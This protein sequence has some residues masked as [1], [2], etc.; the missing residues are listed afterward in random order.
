MR[1]ALLLTSRLGGGSAGHS[2]HL[3]RLSRHCAV[4]RLAPLSEGETARLVQ[5]LLDR[6]AA[7]LEL[8]RWIQAETEGNPLFVVET[9]RLLQRQ[10]HIEGFTS[11]APGELE[12]TTPPRQSVTMPEGIRS[13]V[14]QRLACIESASLRIAQIASI[15]GRSFDE[16]LL[17]AVAGARRNRLSRLIDHLLREDIFER[18]GAGYRF[19]HDKIRAVCYESLPIRMRRAYHSRAAATLVQMPEVPI[20][21]LAWH[22]YSAGHWHLATTSWEHA[23][24]HASNIFAHAEA[25]RAYRFAL[26]CVRRDSPRDPGAADLAEARL[27]LKCEAILAIV[28]RPA[29]RAPI[30]QRVGF[31]LE[32]TR[33][34]SVEVAL[35]IRKA[36]LEE[37]TGN[38]GLAAR[39]ARSAWAAAHKGRD[40]QAEVEALRVLAWALNRSWRHQRSLAI[41]RL[42]LGKMA[43]SKTRAAV[44]LLWQ[45]AGA[46]IKL[47]DYE[48]ASAYSER[49]A[50]L[51]VELGLKTEYGHAL[52]TR[53]LIERC[54][55]RVRESRGTTLT[56]LQLAGE[57]GDPI[58]RARV[59]NQLVAL[60]ELEGQLG[61]ALKRLRNTILVSRSAGYTR[62][63][64]SGL[65][66]VA[67]GI[68]RLIGNYTWAWNASGHALALCRTTN[69][70]LLASLYLLSRAQALLDEARFAESVAVV[71]EALLVM[72]RGGNRSLWA[73]LLAVK[74]A[75]LLGLED[76][77]SAIA[78]LEAASKTQSDLGER[79]SLVDPLTYLALAYARVGDFERAVSTSG[80]AMRLLSEINFANMQPQRVFWHHYMIL[81]KF[82]RE[83]RLPYLKRAVE[84]IEAQAATLSKAQA[85]RFRRDVRLNREILEAWEQHKDLQPGVSDTAAA[86]SAAVWSGLA[87]AAEPALAP[88]VP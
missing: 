22:Q 70:P 65:N 67:Y 38:F 60:D 72:D 77:A 44:W 21:Q 34:S 10:G 40:R 5:S 25:L 88:M 75:S 69:N 71:E 76:L 63:H 79:L 2:S 7:P 24:D 87:P 42:A 33:E 51:S 81:E 29:D 55:G 26:D 73:E 20:H 48:S 1:L 37:Y 62:T 83:P 9:L 14:E 17:S 66:E 82:N 13:A 64:M 18:E 23:G 19:A 86:S 3:E 30:L 84:F 78:H 47:S 28:G 61:S 41:T 80:E 46:Y 4:V 31:L 52:M 68:G 36:L 27:Q 6:T 85:R 43:G 11:F 35:H 58:T 59:N 12:R 16:D 57:T 50:S 53:A 49:A 8:I 32:R 39:L 54:V 45:A 56:A 15:L 74:G